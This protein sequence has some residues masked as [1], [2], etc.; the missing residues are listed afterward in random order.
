MARR[1]GL[2]FAVVLLVLGLWLLGFT[3]AQPTDLIAGVAAAVA[4][5]AWYQSWRSANA[6][7]KS[8]SI[9]EANEERRKYG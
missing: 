6:A 7:T 2:L 8:A 9:A 3:P 5:L 4:L 1:I